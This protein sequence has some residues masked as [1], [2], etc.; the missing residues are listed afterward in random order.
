MKFAIPVFALAVASIV[1]VSAQN[2][3]AT[4][5][6]KTKADDT[7]TITM[8]GCVREDPVKHTYSLVGTMAAAVDPSRPSTNVEKSAVGTTGSMA[9]YPLLSPAEVELSTYVGKRVEMSVIKTLP[10]DSP[11]QAKNASNQPRNVMDSQ[12][13]VVSVKPASGTCSTE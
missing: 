8:T 4:T 5:R 3:A 6:T 12:Y 13:T 2:G 10:T 9:T 7:R 1:P 11:A